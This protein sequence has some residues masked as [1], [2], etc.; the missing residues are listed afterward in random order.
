LLQQHAVQYQSPA[1]SFKVYTNSE[2]TGNS[3]NLRSMA[4]N[5]DRSFK[6]DAVWY[7]DYANAFNSARASGTGVGAALNQ[8]R[9]AADL[10]RYEPGTS[11]FKAVL[12]KLQQVNNWDRG[13]ALKVQA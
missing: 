4:E 5:M 9:A 8:A 6:S 10:G 7:A 1:F 2:D 11:P 12:A 3:Y 13:A